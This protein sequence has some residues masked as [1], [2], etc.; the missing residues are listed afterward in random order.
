LDITINE[1]E[2]NENEFINNDFISDKSNLNESIN[3]FLDNS[4]F[5]GIITGRSKEESINNI[6]YNLENFKVSIIK[7]QIKS[8]NKMIYCP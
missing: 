6:L 3:F 7:N 2:F 8:S 4:M 1:A 5:S